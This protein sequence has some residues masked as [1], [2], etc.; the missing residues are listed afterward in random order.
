MTNAM[1]MSLA[2]EKY[3]DCGLAPIPLY[4]RSKRPMQNDWPNLVTDDSTE[5]PGN[6]GVKC[7]AP[8]SGVVD[9]DLDC[10]EARLLA[11]LVMPPTAACFGRASALSSHRLY[12]CEPP[13]EA[14]RQWVGD[15]GMILEVRSTGGQTMFPRPSTRAVS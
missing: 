9:L 15:N 10:A 5:W 7:G 13:P 8:S 6:I 12:Q 2:A 1:D 14:T 3:R 4:P 11:P